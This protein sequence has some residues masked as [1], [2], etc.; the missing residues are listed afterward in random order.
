MQY[1]RLYQEMQDVAVAGFIQGKPKMKASRSLPA[2]FGMKQAVRARVGTRAYVQLYHI[3]P[4]HPI[5]PL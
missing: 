3:Y 1:Q 5:A 4:I 2:A